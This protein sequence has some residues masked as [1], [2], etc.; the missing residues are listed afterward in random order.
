VTSN[1]AHQ[2]SEFSDLSGAINDEIVRLP[3]WFCFEGGP[4]PRVQ[5][6]E[7]DGRLGDLLAAHGQDLG[8]ALF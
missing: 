8:N 6:C 3:K 2:E 7:V 5:G 4:L 1:G